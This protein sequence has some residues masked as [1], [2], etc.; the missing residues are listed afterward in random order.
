MTVTLYLRTRTVRPDRAR[1]WP[2]TTW[3]RR[4]V[5]QG[6]AGSCAA[7]TRGWLGYIGPVSDP[8]RRLLW[9]AVVETAGL[10]V[11]VGSIAISAARAGSGLSALASE[12]LVYASF[13]GAMLLIC[14]GLWRRRSWAR[15]PFLMAQ[16][17]GLVAAWLFVR[18][19]APVTK[20]S[21]LVLA[22][23]SVLGIV[24]V[25]H[26]RVTAALATRSA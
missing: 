19:D 3:A 1:S 14:R 21:G 22:A 12:L 24:L 18:A 15:T 10:A 7:A 17:F 16:M 6:A 4:A 23:V 2:D 8:V 9:I 5:A 11:L 20:V 25:L 13:L 26:P